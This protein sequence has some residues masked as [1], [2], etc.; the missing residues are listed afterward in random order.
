MPRLSDISCTA[1]S[2]GRKSVWS[3][4]LIQL[5]TSI[6]FLVFRA[7]KSLRISF[8][9]HFNHVLSCTTGAFSPTALVHILFT[10]F[11]CPAPVAFIYLI[12]RIPLANHIPYL[13]RRPSKK[14]SCF[15]REPF[16]LTNNRAS[17]ARKAH[18]PSAIV[19]VEIVATQRAVSA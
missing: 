8:R 18:T 11:E 15:P 17:P 19:R 10:R 13:G 4:S 12:L 6:L 9:P 1:S 5:L 2:N 16:Y 7:E 14:I 3:P